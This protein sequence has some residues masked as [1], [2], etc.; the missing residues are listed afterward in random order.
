M[1]RTLFWDLKGRWRVI[2]R[3]VDAPLKYIANIVETYIVLYKICIISKDMFNREWIEEAGR[4]LQ[5]K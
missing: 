3:R 5:I 4:E 2:L 1:R